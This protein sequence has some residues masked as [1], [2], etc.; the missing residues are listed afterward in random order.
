MPGVKELQEF[1]PMKCEGDCHYGEDG[2][3]VYSPDCPVHG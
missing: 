3:P 1:S 2:K